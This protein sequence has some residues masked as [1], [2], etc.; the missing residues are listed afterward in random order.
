M[1]TAVDT[2]NA[3]VFSICAYL[4]YGVAVSGLSWRLLWV[5]FD[6]SLETLFH[7]FPGLAVSISMAYAIALRVSKCRHAT[8]LGSLI[9]TDIG[10][11]VLVFLN[12]IPSQLSLVELGIRANNMNIQ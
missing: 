10:I 11:V 4:G 12:M 6:I 9:S 3:G 8:R 2:V 5:G 1:G 7:M